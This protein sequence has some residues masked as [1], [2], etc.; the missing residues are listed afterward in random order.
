MPDR[1]QFSVNVDENVTKQIFLMANFLR[2]P[3]LAPNCTIHTP[4]SH[5]FG[6]GKL[7]TS[8][9]IQIHHFEKK[10]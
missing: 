8:N 10:H 6:C 1:R 4:Q 3:E 7:Q 9:S 5:L 2:I